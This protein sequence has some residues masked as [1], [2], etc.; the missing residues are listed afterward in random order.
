MFLLQ[1]SV[2]DPIGV[3]TSRLLRWTLDQVE[4]VLWGVGVIC[5]DSSIRLR[6]VGEELILA[7]R[8]ACRRLCFRG[9][10]MRSLPPTKRKQRAYDALRKGLG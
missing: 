1:A 10:N 9:R 5:G 4:A 7:G 3:P 6:L 2:T 8:L